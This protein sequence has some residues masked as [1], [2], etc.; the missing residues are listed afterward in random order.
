MIENKF[1]AQIQNAITHTHCE[2]LKKGNGGF[3]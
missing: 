1:S 2:T 3:A